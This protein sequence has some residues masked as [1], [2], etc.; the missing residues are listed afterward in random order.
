MKIFTLSLFGNEAIEINE[1]FKG[2]SDIIASWPTNIF[3]IIGFEKDSDS[4]FFNSKIS[5]S[6]SVAILLLNRITFEIPLVYLIFE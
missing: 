5:S 1:P 6:S 4:I 2:P 3:W